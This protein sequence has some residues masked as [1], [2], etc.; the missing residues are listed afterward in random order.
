MATAAAIQAILDTLSPAQEDQLKVR[1]TSVE[2]AQ[3]VRLTLLSPS[4]L[5]ALCA[6]VADAYP[7]AATRL[8]AII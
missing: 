1:L 4:Q 5:N 7:P 6:A 8:L 2:R 3:L